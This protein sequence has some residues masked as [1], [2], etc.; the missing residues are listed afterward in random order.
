MAR[1]SIKEIFLLRHGEIDLPDCKT[2]A[3]SSDYPLNE[4][5]ADQARHL[6][7][8]ISN[9]EIEMIYCSDLSRSIQTAE[10]IAQSRTPIMETPCLREI[11]LGHWEGLTKYEIQQRYPG[12]WEMRGRDFGS[13]RPKG[14]ESFQDLANRVVPEF[15]KILTG[16]QRMVALVGHSTVNRT[17]IGWIL[18]ISFQDI[19]GFRQDYG[20][21][22]IIEAHRGRCCLKLL[23]LVHKIPAAE[24]MT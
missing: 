15:R 21:M 13:F 18:N 10:I 2:L 11:H 22:N 20:A 14:G 6:L 17:I 8:M 23:N 5:G 12:Q 19:F 9:K 16:P 4:T 3:G 1:E 24:S 7:K